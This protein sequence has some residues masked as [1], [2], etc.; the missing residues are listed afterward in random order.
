MQFTYFPP[1]QQKQIEFVSRLV[2]IADKYQVTIYTCSS[3]VIE[4]VP[5]VKK[6]HCIDGA[7][8]EELFG[9]RASRAKDSGQRKECGC[10][11]SKDIGGYDNQSCRHGCVYCYAR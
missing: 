1:S 2:E 11:R 3:P 4:S 8:L 5:G 6:G 9:K 7:Y 10:T